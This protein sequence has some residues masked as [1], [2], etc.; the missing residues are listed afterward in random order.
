MPRLGFMGWFWDSSDLWCYCSVQ[1][2]LEAR[3]SVKSD[4]FALN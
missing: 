3:S 4:V 2:S 1:D